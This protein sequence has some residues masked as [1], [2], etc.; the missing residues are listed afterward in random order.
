MKKWKNWP[1]IILSESH[2]YK[3]GMD[4]ICEFLHQW[5]DDV[6]DM[7]DKANW[8]VKDYGLEQFQWW[9]GRKIEEWERFNREKI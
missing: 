7:M 2:K 5:P 6:F 1:E 3:I 9:L 8:S 4:L